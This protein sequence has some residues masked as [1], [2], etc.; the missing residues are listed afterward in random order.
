MNSLSEY[1]ENYLIDIHSNDY[2]HQLYKL[3]LEKVKKGETVL[4]ITSE[5]FDFTKLTLE[6]D[7][8]KDQ[9]K[10]F[11]IMCYKSFDDISRKLLLLHSW[12]LLP[13]LVV[14]DLSQLLR[15]DSETSSSLMPKVALCTVSLLAYLDSI[16]MQRTRRLVDDLAVDKLFGLLILRSDLENF[17]YKQIQIL[18]DL[19]FYKTNLYQNLED[20]T[21]ILLQKEKE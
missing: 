2:L 19:Y 7:V 3:C 9:L 12:S 4:L 14:V 13:R 16:A 8:S 11:I 15:N 5:L 18:K 1:L 10:R 6:L 21:S 17:G 20:I